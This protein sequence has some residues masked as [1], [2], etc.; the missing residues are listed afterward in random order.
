MKLEIIVMPED[1]GYIANEYVDSR[2]PDNPFPGKPPVVQARA[3]QQ[4]TQG[5][6]IKLGTYFKVLGPIGQSSSDVEVSL[7]L[8]PNGKDP[9]WGGNY[10]WID[11]PINTNPFG[12]SVT[13]NTPAGT[14]NLCY[15]YKLSNGTW[16]YWYRSGPYHFI[17]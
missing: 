1:Q 17:N 7:R 12:F 14:Y 2:A 9:A 6:T 16:S 3:L 5:T 11:V 15:C 8:Y 10:Q 13:F 4:P